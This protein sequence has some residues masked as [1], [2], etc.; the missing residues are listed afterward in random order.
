MKPEKQGL[1]V[2]GSPDHLTMDTKAHVSSNK[3]Y[4]INSELPS[5]NSYLPT[6]TNPALPKKKKQTK[7]IKFSF[8]TKEISAESA[9]N[10]GML[11]TP[12]SRSALTAGCP[13]AGWS[14]L[15]HTGGLGP[16]QPHGITPAGVGSSK[17][18]CPLVKGIR[19]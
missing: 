16:G 1:S 15:Y 14:I 9:R 19:G 11:P 2:L 4:S 7:N 18:L 6:L 8:K 12:A 17:A 10:L 5:P 3:L 13:E